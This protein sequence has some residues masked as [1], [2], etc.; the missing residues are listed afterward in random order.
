M[1]KKPTQAIIFRVRGITW[2][3]DL[4]HR[5]GFLAELARL[6]SPWCISYIM[7]YSH[8][9]DYN[10]Y[11]DGGSYWYDHTFYD[12]HPGKQ[13]DGEKGLNFLWSWHMMIS[14]YMVYHL[15]VYDDLTLFDLAEVDHWQR[16]LPIGSPHRKRSR[17]ALVEIRMRKY[18]LQQGVRLSFFFQYSKYHSEEIQ[19][20]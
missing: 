7:D 8:P 2:V 16:R 15:L 18:L 13:N 12:N 6:S 9:G 14:W 4:Y 19:T 11:G 20:N 5:D 3:A 1:T 17:A 10:D